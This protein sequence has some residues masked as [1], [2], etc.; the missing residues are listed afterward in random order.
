MTD[1]AKWKQEERERLARERAAIVTPADAAR[2][3]RAAAQQARRDALASRPKAPRKKATKEQRAKW[4]RT[5]REREKEDPERKN[6]RRRAERARVARNPDALARAT[7]SEHARRRRFTAGGRPFVGVDGEGAGEDDKGRQHYM[8]LRAGDRELWTGKP[9]TTLQC[10]D[11]L[12]DCPASRSAILVGFSFGY[13][14]TMI[15]RDL[16][17]ERRAHLLADKDQGD[18]KSRYTYWSGGR[19]SHGF[20]IEYLKNNYFRVCRTILVRGRDGR[21]YPKSV[22]GSSRTIYETFGFFQSSFLKT[23]KAWEVGTADERAEIE[24]NKAERGGV[25][26][27]RRQRD[28]CAMECRFLAETMEKFRAVC[29]DPAVNIKPRTWNGAGKLSSA[30]HSQWD[31]M[32]AEMLASRLASIPGLDTGRFIEAASAA[33]YGGRFEVTRI[34]AIS[35]PVWEYDI[36]SAYPAAMRKLPCLVHGE[37][38]EVAPAVLKTLNPERDIFVAPLRFAHSAKFA[39]R[40][41]GGS[42]GRANVCGFPVRQKSGRLFWPSQGGGVYWSCEIAAAQKLGAQVAY[43]G[44]GWL[45]GTPCRCRTFPH[46]APLYEARKSLGADLRGY[47]IKLAINGL[48]GKLAQRIG[49]PRFANLIWAGL[50]TAMTRAALSAA[51]AHDPEAVIMFATDGIFTTRPLPLDLGEALGQWEAKEHGRLFIVQ[52]GIYWGASRPKMRGVPNSVLT[53]HVAEFEN[54]WTDFCERDRSA[55]KGNA[56]VLPP[57]VSVPIR[58]FTGIRIAQARGKP[59]TAGR[60]TDSPRNFDFSWHA[61]RGRATWNARGIDD[62]EM[63][64][65][66]FPAPGSP[67]L[68][69]RPHGGDPQL[70]LQLDDEKAELAEQ[71]DVVDLSPPWTT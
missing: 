25:E 28:Y 65:W 17:S 46:V 24:A 37:W 53:R 1:R 48:Y 68:W 49:H 9:L 22:P 44:P 50:I 54:A 3:E 21:T 57:V 7:A 42:G 67:D 58:L 41:N 12:C 71:P 11:F 56:A 69:S 70:V 38:M 8:L 36:H 43:T 13:D 31:T 32:T 30:L 39:P 47:P 20:G 62:H 52:P 64:V 55:H 23:I 29:L 35:G 63:H 33:Y 27:D 26:I 10:L 2:A 40:P 45:Y 51:A 59:E 4:R 34:G 66:T 16:P 60:W 15:L 14:V 5:A 6:K 61:K 19:R 18:G